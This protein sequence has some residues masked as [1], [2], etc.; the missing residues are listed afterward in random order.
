MTV[1][2]LI[3]FIAFDN[4]LK[5]FLAF[6]LSINS[7][8]ST[9]WEKTGHFDTFWLFQLFQLAQACTSKQKFL[10]GLLMISKPARNFFDLYELVQAQ[11][12]AK[13]HERSIKLKS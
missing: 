5:L 2:E 9:F 6:L 11:K 8:I 12:R 3:D 10:A 4:F 1:E 7:L 13:V